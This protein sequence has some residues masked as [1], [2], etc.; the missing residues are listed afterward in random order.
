MGSGDPMNQVPARLL[1]RAA[2]VER[3]SAPAAAAF[4]EAA[5]MV[6]TALRDA[7][8]ERLNLTAAARV[9]GYSADHLSR[10]IAQGKLRN[11]GR[12]HAPLVMRGE[13][14]MKPRATAPA[15][16]LRLA[17]GAEADPMPDPDLMARAR[18]ARRTR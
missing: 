1:E 8:G 9:S 14:P 18:R 5:E 17:A 13:L 16:A 3:F 10:L 4:R 12:K 7:A 15:P 6:E 2:D 11:V